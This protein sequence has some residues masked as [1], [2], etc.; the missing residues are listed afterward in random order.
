MKYTF[1]YA[2]APHTLV[3]IVTLQAEWGV[4][5]TVAQNKPDYSNFQPIF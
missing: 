2:A 4:G 5:Y 3:H 1:H